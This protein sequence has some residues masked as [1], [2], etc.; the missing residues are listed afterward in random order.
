MTYT[1]SGRTPV[2]SENVASHSGQYSRSS[3]RS[4][5]LKTTITGL[6]ASAA[7][8]KNCLTAA[9]LYFCCV[10][11]AISTSATRRIWSA[12]SQ[13]TAASES[14]SGVSNSSNRGGTESATRQKIKCSAQSVRAS[15]SDCQRRSSKP[16]NSR[17][18]R[19]A[20]SSKPGGTRQTGC[21]V[22][23]ASGLTALAFW[24]AR[25]LNTT[26]L[27]MLVPPTTATTSAGLAS[28]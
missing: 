10:S 8:R 14:T 5:W 26:D 6:S 15:F 18:T 21:L 22:P 9:S 1:Y 25:W 12:R 28:S 23:A 2:S 13:L 20:S 11:T 17:E 7:L 3:V 27:P 4:H 24:P 16:S 19:S